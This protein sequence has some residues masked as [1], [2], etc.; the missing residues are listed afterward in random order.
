[1]DREPALYDARLERGC[2]LQHSADVDLRHAAVFHAQFGM[3][4]ERSSQL[5]HDGNSGLDVIDNDG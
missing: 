4:S 3:R 5:H 1:M 2:S